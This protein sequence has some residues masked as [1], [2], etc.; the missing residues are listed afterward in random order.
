MFKK[1][2][3][4]TSILGSGTL[5]SRFLGF[6]RDILIAKFFGT[7]SYLE[8]FIVAFRLPNIFRSV[9]AE[10][11]ADSV[12]I[13]HL[14]KYQED[15]VRLFKLSNNLLSLLTVF[16]LLFTLVGVVFSKYLI[17]LI[18]P[19]FL[20][21]PAKFTLTVS[22]VR[23]TFFYLFMIGLSANI[24]A[25]L[26][27]LKKFFVP[28]ITGAFLNI[29]FIVG[30]LFFNKYFKEYILVICVIVAGILQVVSPFFSL[31]KE[32][33]YLRFNLAASFKDKELIRMLKLFIPRIGSSIIYHLS[34]IIDTI[35]ASFTKIV[36]E[37]ALAAIYYSNR[38]IQLPLAII[39]LSISR[40]AV[41]DLSS[42]ATHNNLEDFKKLF[43]FSFQNI[44]FFVIPICS[45][46]I[47]VPNGI[48]DTIFKRGEFGLSSLRI[49]S[50]V[51]FFY[52][53]GLFFFCA[54]KLLVNTFYSLKDTFTPTKTSFLSL[55]I[56]VVLSAFL[57]FPLKI[58][59]VA[60]GSSLAAMFN[61][62]LLY[63]YLV[64]KIGKI[65]WTDTKS[66]LIKVIV[67]SIIIGILSRFLW[68]I[69]FLH[70]Y[71]K[72]IIISLVTL[73][74]LIFGGLLLDLKQIKYMKKMVLKK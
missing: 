31:K 36:G 64:K 22:F 7:S 33:F 66:Q 15:K 74:M 11:F 35:F 63:H 57:I 38:L 61:F 51:L 59:G 3:K 58:G 65:D 29:S 34:V 32:G 4:D 25:I 2:I 17:I 67:L 14:A 9:F 1:I 19:G 8:A 40:V 60:L 28:A 68:N 62:F 30:L 37:G 44:I 10:G 73:S 41:V 43:V 50:S 72:M 20:N 53:F 18:A 39:A 47:F 21:D 13:P 69:I 56:N 46:F 70:K 55:F 45:L 42:Y 6:I 54:I 24:N 26:Y 5:F 12:A 49:T 52:S 48:I 71:L 27:A 16:I 23:I